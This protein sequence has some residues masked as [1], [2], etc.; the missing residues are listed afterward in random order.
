MSRK[1]YSRIQTLIEEE[2]G[3]IGEHY[4]FVVAKYRNQ[5]DNYFHCQFGS[6]TSGCSSYPLVKDAQVICKS[7]FYMHNRRSRGT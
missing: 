4:G 6:S 5:C 2:V 1:L 7:F 3:V